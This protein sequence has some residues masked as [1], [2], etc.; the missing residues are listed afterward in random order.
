MLKKRLIPILFLK[1]GHLVRSE[2]FSI[3]QNLGNPVK[4]VERYNDWDVDELIYIDISEDN[5]HDSGREDLKVENPN[6]IYDVITM[7]AE[8]CFMPLTFGGRIK[9]IED[10][11]KRIFLGADKVTLN[12]KALEDISFI[13]K[14]AK[15]FGSQ[16]IIISIDWKK[17]NDDYYVY[18]NGGKKKTKWDP[19]NWAKEVEK[20]GAGEILLNSIDRDGMACGYDIYISK[21]VCE[22]VKIPVILCGGVGR[23]KDFVQGIQ[24]TKASAVAAGNI[25]NFKELSYIFA[26][27]ELK[28][29]KLDFR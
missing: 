28:R 1:N 19:V 8:K 17:E 29:S 21:L 14:A 4:Q 11:R 6:S 23:Y 12:T 9:T 25:F 26:K 20:W 16:A 24:E 27:K 13:S 22:A 18:S 7:V 2:L 5:Y 15:E 10:I 3:H